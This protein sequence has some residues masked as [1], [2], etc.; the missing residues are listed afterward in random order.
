M[1]GVQH[2]KNAPKV[3]PG[4]GFT[5]PGLG[6]APLGVDSVGKPLVSCY[7]FNCNHAINASARSCGCM[8]LGWRSPK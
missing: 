1:A 3:S 5:T 4:E 2:D 7:F 8:R 6:V